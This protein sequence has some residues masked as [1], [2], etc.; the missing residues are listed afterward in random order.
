MFKCGRVFKVEQTVQRPWSKKV[1]GVW[2]IERRPV[3]LHDSE[4]GGR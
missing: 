3:L 4:L 2:G 1:I